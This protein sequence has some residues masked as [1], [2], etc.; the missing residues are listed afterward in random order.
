MA[1]NGLVNNSYSY[2]YSLEERAKSFCRPVDR[3][4]DQQN[5][6]YLLDPH[7]GLVDVQ[8]GR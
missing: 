1:I 8:P 7:C 4:F 2:S 3:N 5:E 6:P